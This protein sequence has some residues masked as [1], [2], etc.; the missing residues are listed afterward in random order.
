MARQLVAEGVVPRIS[1]DTVRR[2][3]EH[4]HLKPWRHH[5]W[6]SPKVPRNEAF[7]AAA[8]ALKA[9]EVSQPVVT[10][11]GVHL[12]QVTGEKP[13]SKKL[14]EVREDVYRAAEARLFDT[15]VASGRKRAKV[16]H[17]AR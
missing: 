11:F 2:V 14:A 8:F 15:L 7:A 16:E 12:I 6:L 9:G 10:P 1:P 5:L 17:A 13:G 4:H 3:L